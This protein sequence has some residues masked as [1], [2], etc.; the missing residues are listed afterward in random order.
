MFGLGSCF[1]NTS[2]SFTLF[3]FSKQ[4]Q[5]KIKVSNF[6]NSRTFNERMNFQSNNNFIMPINYSKLYKE[7]VNEIQ[8]WIL[9]NKLPISLDESH[10]FK[11]IDFNEFDSNHLQP[12]YYSQRYIDIRAQ[13]RPDEI[14]SLKEIAK[15]Y[16]F[17]REHQPKIQVGDI[18]FSSIKLKEIQ[19]VRD[20]NIKAIELSQFDIIIRAI[21]I[22]S[23][24]LFLYFMSQT[25][26][27]LIEMNKSNTILPRIT[28]SNVK[29]VPV[30]IQK[31]SN[32]YYRNLVDQYFDNESFIKNYNYF[33]ELKKID[34]VY[35]NATEI[36]ELELVTE[37]I[38]H[39]KYLKNK[40]I[41]KDLQEINNCFSIE[42]YKAT[43]ILIGSVLEA[44]LLDWLSEIDKV[45]YLRAKDKRITLND[46]IN[47]LKKTNGLKFAENAHSIRRSRNSVHPQKFLSN[48]A[49][50]KESTEKLVNNLKEIIATRE[51]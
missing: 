38:L 14:V 42:A 4:K 48:K 13:L 30:L 47:Q 32:Q 2:I 46:C 27:I 44:F 34:Y 25:G 11:E 45:D 49:I 22:S 29:E 28:L 19:L 41:N 31:E 16:S 20:E 17:K 39:F 50:D 9:T 7:Y 51:K 24:Y 6:F 10:E 18:V 15:I 43:T 1:T 23:E 36:L 35:T 40:L 5:D 3:V 12:Y 8:N 37:S 21:E 26:K 33:E